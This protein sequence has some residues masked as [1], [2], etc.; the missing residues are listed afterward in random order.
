MSRPQTGW[1]KTR[2]SLAIGLL[3]MWL[4]TTRPAFAGRVSFVPGGESIDL[5]P[6]KQPKG[7]LD[8]TFVRAIGL[9]PAAGSSFT[10]T[11]VVDPLTALAH[12]SATADTT[13]APPEIEVAPPNPFVLSTMGKSQEPV[14]SI[15]NL[16][17]L[18]SGMTGLTGLGALACVRRV[19]RALR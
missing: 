9:A 14:K 1:K 8:P 2:S 18:W 19:R 11:P 4:A 6:T 16:P 13:Q 3:G 5:Q 17:A 10:A 15:P 12:F 7:D